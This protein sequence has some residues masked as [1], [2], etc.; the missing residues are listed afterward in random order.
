MNALVSALKLDRFS[1]AFLH[2]SQ[3]I[4]DCVVVASMK[5][6]VGHVGNKQG[7]LNSASHRFEMNQDFF[8]C[9]WN[10]VAISQHDISQA[11]TNQDHIDTSFIH[12]ACGRII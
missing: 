5:C 9:D 2:K 3:R 6:P 11:V 4:S 8:E 1:T 12:Y 7:A 10:R